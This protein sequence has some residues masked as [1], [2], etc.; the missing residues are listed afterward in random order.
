[1]G[2]LISFWR[3][4]LFLLF[5]PET[6]PLKT[7]SCEMKGFLSGSVGHCEQNWKLW[8]FW[9]DGNHN[10]LH[11][12]LDKM[13]VT[14]RNQTSYVHRGW[15]QSRPSPLK[16]DMLPLMI[17]VSTLHTEN[18]ITV[19]NLHHCSLSF[20]RACWI[21]E[22]RVNTSQHTSGQKPCRC[23]SFRGVR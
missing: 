4:N 17:S 22:K 19:L 5:D 23:V 7:W 16:V 14:D 8:L 15:R 2:N 21:T 6:H 1:M 11:R 3:I 12:A 10:T 13:W 18:V 9:Q 20:C